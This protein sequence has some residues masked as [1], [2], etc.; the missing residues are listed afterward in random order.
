MFLSTLR[1]LFTS[2]KATARPSRRRSTLTL[3]P[4][5]D[6]AVPADLV[7]TSM[8]LHNDAMPE[9]AWGGFLFGTLTPNL[10]GGTGYT[11]FTLVP[12]VGD[13]NNANF[14]TADNQLRTTS[15][16]NFEAMGGTLNV[17]I[18]ATAANGVQGEDTFALT[19]TNINERP[20]GVSL[21]GNTVPENSPG[22][23]PIGTISSTDLDGVDPHTYTLVNSSGGRFQITGNTLEVAP[24][25]DLNYETQ[26]GFYIAIRATDAG[27]LATTRG[28][29]VYL[30]N[31]SEAPTGLTL[32]NNS[33]QEATPSGTYVGT[34]LATDPEYGAIT[35][36]LTDDAGGRFAVNGPN[37][38]V[39]N[40]TLLDYETATSHNVTVQ[41]TGP[42]G[43]T[44]QVFVINVTNANE[45]P[46]DIALSNDTLVLP[47]TVVGSFSATDPDV[48]DTA[49]FIL[50]NNANGKFQLVGN[51]LQTTDQN[52]FVYDPAPT[53]QIS[54]LV[55]DQGGRSYTE[56][57]TIN[58]SGIPTGGGNTAPTDI[59]I[60]GTSVDENSA[61]GT[62]I[63]TLSATDDSPNPVTYTLLDDAGGRFAI[64]G[65]NLT[66]ANGLL[67]NYE[68][69][70]THDIKIR[71]TDAGNLTYDEVVTITVNNVNEAPTDIA[72]TN[73]TLALPT[74]AGFVVGT[75]SALDPDAAQTFTFFMAENGAG[76]FT[77]VG[78]DIVVA[79]P[80][81]FVWDPQ[82]SYQVHVYVQDQG[83]AMYDEWFTI[84]V[85]NFV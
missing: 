31:V 50:T 20:T 12:G 25:A 47:A 23:T 46:T 80:D 64:S 11:S 5:E 65:V 55:L 45:A 51:Q 63:G 8:T 69:S 16:F 71:A 75:L 17:R 43:S 44:T 85:S 26:R 40:G 21:A 83:G 67:L 39:A 4:L 27:G 70:T 22:G 61:V 6:R 37:I 19:L 49:T 79:D 52:L 1:R 18:R 3:N 62:Y 42:G 29:M 24:G 54:V 30:S 72:L 48:G 7:G 78:N 84:T 82:P 41:A 35:Y 57:F 34:L 58:V 36:S 68:A 81:Q 33:V 59:A 28:F 60:T 10:P 56:N 77:I 2:A 66:V 13:T 32:T 53:Y 9:N 73:D 14:Y 74:T 76:K 38:V 15:N